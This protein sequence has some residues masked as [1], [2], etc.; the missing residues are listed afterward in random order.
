MGSAVFVHAVKVYEALEKQS[1]INEHEERV[2]EGY[3]IDLYRQVGASSRY[4][5]PIRKLLDS[6]QIDPCIEFLQRG[7][8]A[9][10]SIIKLNHPPPPEWST[11]AE[12][13]LTG[14]GGGAILLAELQ[15]QVN[16]LQAWRESIGEVNLSEA[17]VDFERR[18]KKLERESNGKAKKQKS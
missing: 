18:L 17:L 8:G 1:T 3:L 9:Q 10:V 13:D 5:S 4:Y 6:P 11:I 7:T 16:Q 2:F 14:S 12:S 15:A